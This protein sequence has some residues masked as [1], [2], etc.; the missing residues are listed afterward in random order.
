MA[1][2]CS[3]FDAKT[4]LESAIAKHKRH[5]IMQQ[6]KSVLALTKLNRNFMQIRFTIPTLILMMMIYP[7]TYGIHSKHFTKHILAM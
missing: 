3:V 6:R 5:K 2:L 1:A 7:K 4:L